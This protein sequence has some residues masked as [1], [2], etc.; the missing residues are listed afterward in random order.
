MCA[1]QHCM[2]K[3]VQ[4]KWCKPCTIKNQEFDQSVKCNKYCTIAGG[5]DMWGLITP[6]DLTP[7]NVGNSNFGSVPI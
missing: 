4:I 6:V 1:Y 5:G 2:Q 3:L 7:T